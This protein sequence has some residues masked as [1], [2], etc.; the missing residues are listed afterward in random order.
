MKVCYTPIWRRGTRST[1]VCVVLGFVAGTVCGLWMPQGLIIG[2]F[3]AFAT[4]AALE[5]GVLIESSI[6]FIIIAAFGLTVTVVITEPDTLPS[7]PAMRLV[8]GFPWQLVWVIPLQLAGFAARGFI[9]TR[10]GPPNA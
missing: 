10:S 6:V 8:S 7:H 1:L 4:G 2:A 3:L 5:D 9:A